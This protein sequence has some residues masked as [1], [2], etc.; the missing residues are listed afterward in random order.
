[1]S[2]ERPPTLLGLPSYLASQVSRYGRRYLAVVLGRHDLLLVHYAI[3]TAL[4]DLGPMSQ[5]QLADSLDLDKSHLVTRIDDLE[6][7]KLVRRDR[8]PGDRR[9]HRVTLTAAGGRLVRTL[10]PVALQSQHGLLE[11]LSADEQQTL[12]TLLR[13]VLAANDQQRLGGTTELPPHTPDDD[14][15]PAV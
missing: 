12:L 15:A 4:D 2:G 3:L 1:M 13:R 5:Q 6:S 10:R 14:Q 9:R 7:R 11:T 8:D